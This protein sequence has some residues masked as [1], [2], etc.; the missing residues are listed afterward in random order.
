[1]KN[2]LIDKELENY[3]ATLSH[4]IRISERILMK[5]VAPKFQKMPNPV[6]ILENPQNMK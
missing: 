4:K 2:I 1:M 6:E 5:I 3:G